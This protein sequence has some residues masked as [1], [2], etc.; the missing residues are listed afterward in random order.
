[1][2]GGVSRGRRSDRIVRWGVMAGFGAAALA[3]VAVQ[4]AAHPL[5]LASEAYW[6]PVGPPCRPI[7]RQALL[8]HGLPL[9]QAFEFQGLRLA[10]AAGAA[11]CSEETEPHGLG[12]AAFQVCQMTSPVAFSVAVGGR[13]Y[14]F[15]PG[16]AAPA[17]VTVR[18]GV[19]GC[20]LASNFKDG[21]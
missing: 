19:L 9:D 7:S 6:K 3:V 5:R 20:V 13:E 4:Q 16:A 15:A 14:D 1:M 8:G 12:R 11:F 2:S 18:A 21:D 10:R 17:T